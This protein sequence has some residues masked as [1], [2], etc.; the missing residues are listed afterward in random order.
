ML[1]SYIN[2]LTYYF[3]PSLLNILILKTCYYFL[4]TCRYQFLFLCYIYIKTR[5]SSLFCCFLLLFL[6]NLSLKI[7]FVQATDNKALAKSIN[8]Y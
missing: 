6:N 8:I 5:L 7:L 1:I 2:I 3:N 4:I